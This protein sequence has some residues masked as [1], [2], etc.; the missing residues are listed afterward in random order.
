MTHNT[1]STATLPRQRSIS[2]ARH[3]QHALKKGIFV[4][5]THLEACNA[6]SFDQCTT[7]PVL[8]LTAG[9][10]PH[11]G[12]KPTNSACQVQGS[13][14]TIATRQLRRRNGHAA[15]VRGAQP[16]VLRQRK[17]FCDSTV[18]VPRRPRRRALRRRS[19]RHSDASNNSQLGSDL[20]QKNTGSS[21]NGPSSISGKAVDGGA[22]QHGQCSSSN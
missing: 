5:K 14:T 16:D 11:P 18:N 7:K 4:S 17:I 1:L 9:A 19:Q 15:P 8:R 22:K 10:F 12:I 3:R 13:A 21:S 2:C 20:H 6:A